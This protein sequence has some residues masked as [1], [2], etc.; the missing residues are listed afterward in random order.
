MSDKIN[1]GL[2]FDSRNVDEA[3]RS[4]KQ[5]AKV[6]GSMVAE[7]LKMKEASEGAAKGE[8]K[9]EKQIKKI[10]ISF[11]GLK[12]ASSDF[13][14]NFIPGG[15]HILKILGG[16]GKVLG[17]I[18]RVVLAP[19]IAPFKWIMRNGLKVFN[20]LT[21]FS[22]RFNEIKDAALELEGRFTRLANLTG[23]ERFASKINDW[24]YTMLQNLPILRDDLRDFTVQ[25]Q[26][27][28][29]NATKQGKAL[30]GITAAAAGPG[31]SYGEVIG[32]VSSA[33]RDGDV[34]GLS[35]ALGNTLDPR[36]I[37]AAMK[38]V[39]GEQQRF[40]AITNLLNKEYGENVKR[41]NRTINVNLTQISSY[42]S[43]F[44]EQ[45][46]GSPE[47]GNLMWYVQEIFMNAK[48]WISRNK[49]ALMSFAKSVQ[50]V[51]GGVGKMA[52]ELIKG[53]GKFGVSSIGG[54][55][56]AATKF[57]KWAMV[58]RVHL[59]YWALKIADVFNT[60]TKE[61]KGF[62]ETMKGLWNQV[63]G[64]KGGA[65]D[66]FWEGFKQ[67]GTMVIDW[68]AEK[69]S[70]A[71]GNSFK[72]SIAGVFKGEDNQFKTLT[73]DWIIKMENRRLQEQTITGDTTLGQFQRM[74]MG[75]RV[76]TKKTM[77]GAEVLKAHKLKQELAVTQ[78]ELFRRNQNTSFAGMLKTMI[79]GS[80]QFGAGNI[81]SDPS[82]SHKD[83]PTALKLKQKVDEMTPTAK[84]GGD[85]IS[86]VIHADA[87][88]N[89]DAIKKATVAG[90]VKAK[91]DL[92]D[93]S[94]RVGQGTRTTVNN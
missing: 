4:L 42:W 36:K 77:T 2:G 43:E 38:G 21:D 70:N 64:G 30:R 68:L 48:G 27:L 33:A 86:I 84:G 57:K 54:I 15:K 59:E 81:L 60:A 18:G 75:D 76:K 5:N 14:L 34:M 1:L 79:S 44:K 69:I 11:K 91:K 52:Y 65:L 46:V 7:F 45:M 16:I 90:I 83:S 41:L 28:G 72:K 12:K 25:M 55:E 61:G 53:V 26:Q 94:G 47:K 9:V 37:M 63:F 88:T 6:L 24:Q 8:E 71:F 17:G 49:P 82:F 31:N 51:L 20:Y 73:P 74:S 58:A 50:T 22:S 56:A 85:K 32:A 62:W 10:G 67:K 93:R 80:P 39:F 40:L 78:T 13:L 92:G 23:S 3:T 29:I 35:Q 19:V 89:T 87:G 66:L